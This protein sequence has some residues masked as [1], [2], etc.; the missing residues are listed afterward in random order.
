VKADDRQRPR[1]R[2][3]WWFDWAVERGLALVFIT[4]TVL[5]FGQV[6]ARYAFGHPITWTEE[7]CRYLFVWVVFVGAG[8]AERSR[9][10]IHAGLPDLPALASVRRRLDV[11]NGILCVGMV[12]LLFRLVRLVP[13][14]RLYATAV[15]F[16]RTTRGVRRSR[17][18]D[19]W[20]PHDAQHHPDEA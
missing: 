2:L 20:P 4:F 12:L 6:I 15:A 18:P 13:D 1:R 11:V 14:R 19:R 7:V 8:V 17:D 3:G 10:H 16:R 9:A 5:S